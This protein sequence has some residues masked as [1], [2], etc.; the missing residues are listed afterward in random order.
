M[1]TYIDI[2]DCDQPTTYS[3]RVRTITWGVVCSM[4]VVYKWSHLTNS[5]MSLT[6][7]NH[8][9]SDDIACTVVCDQVNEVGPMSV[10]R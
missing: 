6:K 5:I 4:Y 8:L 1:A 7:T 10:Y 3:H 9:A 2:T